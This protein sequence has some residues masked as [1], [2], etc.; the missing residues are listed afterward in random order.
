MYL[1]IRTH[2]NDIIGL[3]N[4]KEYNSYR[5]GMTHFV[6]KTAHPFESVIINQET[7]SYP[8][9]FTIYLFIWNFVDAARKVS[10]WF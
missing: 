9:T 4:L 2:W 6:S 1:I 5:T 7:I 3:N 10:A 8:L